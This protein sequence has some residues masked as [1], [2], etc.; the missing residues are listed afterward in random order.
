MKNFADRLTDAID[1]KTNPTVMGLDPSLDA[2]PESLKSAYQD[3]CQDPAI[4]S[5]LAIAAFNARLIDATADLIPAVKL[6]SAF[7][8]Q[9]GIPGLSALKD[10]TKYAR[11]K[12]LIVIIDAKRNDIG[13][14][15]EAYARAY[16]DKTEWVDGSQQ[17]VYEADAI[18]LNAY[19]GWD[20]IKPFVDRCT[21]RGK[22]LFILV[23]TSNPSATDL[24]D[25]ALADGRT[26]SEAMA[27]L[28]AAWGQDQV[29]TCGYSSVGA[30]V[31][32]T[33]PE[34]ARSLRR[35]M[36]QTF[37]LVPGYGAQGGTAK[38]AI[39]GFGP[40]GKGGLVNASRSIMMAWKTYGMEPDLFDVAARRSVIDMADALRQALEQKADET[41]QAE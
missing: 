2:I 41:G 25:L 38:D 28:V 24:Q 30:V 19:L 29:G 34:Q 15:A 40:D 11:K 4:A 14:T 13:R 22:G 16:L 7:Y 20:G 12:G 31:G 39:Q 10:T 3:T 17:S 21:S 18:T 27:D 5:G 36:S 33:W 26:V 35:R 32:A 9:Y 37:I 23:R 6:Q 1:K 8:E